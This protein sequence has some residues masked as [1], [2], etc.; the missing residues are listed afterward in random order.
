MAETNS[1]GLIPECPGNGD[2]TTTKTEPGHKPEFPEREPSY[3]APGLWGTW[4][5]PLTPGPIKRKPAKKNRPRKKKQTRGGNYPRKKGPFK[6]KTGLKGPKR[7]PL[8]APTLEKQ[9][10]RERHTLRQRKFSPG[11]TPLAE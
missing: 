1:L 11:G 2:P 6:K 3:K 5:R 4:K 9:K 8:L 10:P 7:N